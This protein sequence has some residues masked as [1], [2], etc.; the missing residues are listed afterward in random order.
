MPQFLNPDAPL[1]GQSVLL[2]ATFVALAAI[3]ALAYALLAD[4]MRQAI[5]RPNVI[6]WMTRIGG[7]ALV[8]MGLAT[9]M[10][11]RAAG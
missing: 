3:N 7:G 8:A 9:A 11:R 10:V 5:R 4:R 1:L 2:I 6:A